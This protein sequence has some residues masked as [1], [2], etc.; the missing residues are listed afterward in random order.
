MP[1]NDDDVFSYVYQH[2][3]TFFAGRCNRSRTSITSS[4]SIN[5]GTQGLGIA[6]LRAYTDDFIALFKGYNLKLTG[7]ED[8]SKVTTVGALADF[9]VKL[10]MK[11][12]AGK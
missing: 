8:Y 12:N 5:I 2:L 6:D 9:L 10:I 1:L 7:R 4:T 3:R 11:Q